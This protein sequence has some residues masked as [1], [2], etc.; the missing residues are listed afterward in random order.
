MDSDWFIPLNTKVPENATGKAFLT[1]VTGQGAE[2][3][4]VTSLIG[5]KCSIVRLVCVFLFSPDINECEENNICGNVAKCE[6]MPGT[7]KCVCPE[8]YAFNMENKKC[9]GKEC[10]LMSLAVYTFY[11]SS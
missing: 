4:K 1:C 10:F 5:V 8:G 6:N 3:A 7:Y 11:H 2:E 9:F